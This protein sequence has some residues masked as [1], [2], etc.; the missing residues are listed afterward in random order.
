MIPEENYEN[1]ENL[2]TPCENNENHA[3][4]KISIRYENH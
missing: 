3:N 4:H 1:N 2:R